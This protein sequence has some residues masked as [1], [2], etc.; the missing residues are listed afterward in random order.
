[1]K[2]IYFLFLTLLISTM[3]FGQLVINELDSDTPGSD[4]AEFLELKWTPNTSLNG[5]I[6]VFFN[7]SNDLSYGTFDLSGK[8]TDANGFFILANE[9]LATGQDIVLPAGTTGFIQNGPDAVAIYQTSAANFPDGTAPSMTNLID[10]LVYGTSDPD[11]DGLL[12]GLGETT[13]WDEN[14]N[15]AKDI[16]SIQRK[17]DGTYETKAPTFRA[18]NDA[19]VCALSLTTTTA[20]CDAFTAGTDTYNVSIGFTGGGSS[21]F[22]VTS[23]SGTV[24][25]DNPTSVADGTITVTGVAEGTDITVT[26]ADG[27]LCNL[28]YTVTS[29]T[30]VATPSLPIYENF[31]YGSTTGDLTTVSGGVWENHSGATPLAY[32]TTSLS[33]TGYSS[34]SIGGSAS[35]SSSNSEDVNRSF[36][37]I[38]SG[39][40]YMSALVNLSTV[41]SGAYFLHLN[42][43]DFRARVGAKD[44]GAGGVL[45]GIGTNSGTLTYGTTSFS[46]NTTYLV[47]A[48]Y[49]VVAGISNLYVLTA[50]VASEPASAEASNTGTGG[51]PI[52]S[53]ALRQA[54]GMPTITLDGLNVATSWGTVLSTNEFSVNDFKIFPNPTSVGYVNITSNNTA[55]MTVVV[56]DILGKQ[57]LNQTV[58]NNRLNVASLKTGMY[59]M[60]ISQDNATI[61]KKLVIK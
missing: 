33:M 31:N 54:S 6:V 21:T 53:V 44:D 23:T 43:T 5:Y 19:A 46:L 2:K 11:D 17:A 51:V 40:V 58:V 24:G 3:S 27:A 29:P 38:A 48:S 8:T 59:I 35:M 10:A 56:Y 61:T 18:S 39:S 14:A 34:S 1:M 47:V 4:T 60:K 16:E 55:A 57:I 49:D 50:P 42:V 15:N 12:A 32:A 45:F 26:V 30:C 9:S 52:S 36:T 7:G 41:G 13:Q 37:P 22:T 28:S 20:T 25:G